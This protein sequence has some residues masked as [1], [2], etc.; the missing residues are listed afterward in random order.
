MATRH[1]IINCVQCEYEAS[2]FIDLLEHTE[3][4]HHVSY[5]PTK[6]LQCDYTIT[7]PKL[8]AAHIAEVH[9]PT[10]ILCPYCTMETYDIDNMNHHIKHVHT[11][12]TT[13]GELPTFYCSSCQMDTP[14]QEL[15]DIHNHRCHNITN[16]KNNV[17][18]YTCLV[19]SFKTPFESELINHT[20]KIHINNIEIPNSL[21]Y[22]CPFC[23]TEFSNKC[24]FFTHYDLVH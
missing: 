5:S 3:K 22:A 8:Y 12:F 7:D 16:K 1:F 15:L 17:A 21:I 10:I 11:Q 2:T 14:S 13:D 9:L 24:D 20:R 18:S 4:N 23:E 19:C 6:C